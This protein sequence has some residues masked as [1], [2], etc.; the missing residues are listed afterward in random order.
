MPCSLLSCACN[1]LPI[2]ALCC[3]WTLVKL[4]VLCRLMTRSHCWSA[5]RLIIIQC[6]AATKVALIQRSCGYALRP[7]LD[8]AEIDMAVQVIKAQNPGCLVA[9]DNCYGEFTAGK[10]P[11]AVSSLGLGVA[12]GSSCCCIIKLWTQPRSEAL[13][14]FYGEHVI[15]SVTHSQESDCSL[16]CKAHRSWHKFLP[17]ERDSYTR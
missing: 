8:I 16:P 6:A 4:A 11:C 3:V 5:K 2:N 13:L 12:A 10:E 9:V 1:A 14:G 7:T 15:H 17:P